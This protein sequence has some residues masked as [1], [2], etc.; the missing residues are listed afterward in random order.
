MQPIFQTSN[1]D[2]SDKVL[3]V[4][5]AG[6]KIE[7]PEATA[8]RI[9]VPVADR[10]SEI[11]KQVARLRS[12][13]KARSGIFSLFKKKREEREAIRAKIQALVTEYQTMNA[14]FSGDVFYNADG[15]ATAEEKKWSNII[16]A[17]I[18]IAIVYVIFFTKTVK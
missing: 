16:I 18:I 10:A 1:A 3:E 4:S 2:G 9:K 14:S 11:K 13:E 12:A 6:Q 5:R 15:A 8:D 17:V 7:I